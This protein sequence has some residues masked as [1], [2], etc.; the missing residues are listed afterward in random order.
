MIYKL[1]ILIENKIVL[2]KFSINLH[3]NKVVI[4]SVEY[5]KNIIKI[6]VCNK[7]Y[8][9]KYIPISFPLEL[10]IIQVTNQIYPLLLI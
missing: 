10:N 4:K 7:F 3:Q 8:G 1:F 6:P 5:D 9:I 2:N